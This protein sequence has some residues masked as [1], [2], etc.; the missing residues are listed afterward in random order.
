ME[1][2]LALLLRQVCFLV[3]T[4]CMMFISFL[5]YY[6]NK[7]VGKPFDR[8][9]LHMLACFLQ[10]DSSQSLVRGLVLLNCAGGMNNKAIV[11]DWRIRLLLPL[12]WVIDALLKQRA[13][14][15]FIFERVTQRC[16]VC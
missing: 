15:S 8:L 6:L 11:D 5:N 7:L 12:L 16:V 10:P 4:E 2:L 13:I 3:L 14:A 9:T 1:V